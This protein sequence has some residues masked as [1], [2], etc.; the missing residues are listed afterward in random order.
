MLKSWSLEF[1]EETI[2]AM[3]IDANGQ[4]IV[5]WSW[6]LFGSSKSFMQGDETANAFILSDVSRK[7]SRINLWS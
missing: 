7:H 4:L 6:V 1:N 5:S 2:S 3:S